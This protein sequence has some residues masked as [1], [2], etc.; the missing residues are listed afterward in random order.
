MANKPFKCESCKTQYPSRYKFANFCPACCALLPSTKKFVEEYFKRV[1]LHKK[2]NDAKRLFL[3]NEYAGAVRVATIILEKE[4]RELIHDDSLFGV[5]LISKAFSFE[6]DEQGKRITREPLIK[7]NLL[8]TKSERNE[9][10]GMKMYCMGIMAGIRNILAHNNPHI[11]P[12]KSMILISD[13]SF[14]I[15]EIT[16]G[17]TIF[18]QT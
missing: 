15:H 6:Y 1:G 7:I 14:I 18:F 5:V 4:I 2:L 3:K 17:S 9:Q 13:I 11:I 8:R 16:S 10:E 12:F